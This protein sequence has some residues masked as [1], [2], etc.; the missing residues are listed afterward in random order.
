MLSWVWLACVA[1]VFGLVASAVNHIYG[2][3][4]KPCDRVERLDGAARA[5]GKIED[6][7]FRANAGDPARQERSVGE[8][9]SL[10][11]HVLGKSGYQAFYR[12]LSRLG[13][14]VARA[15][16]RAAGGQDQIDC[17]IPASAAFFRNASI[18]MRFVRENGGGDDFPA[19][20]FATCGTAGRSDLRIF[21][22]QRNR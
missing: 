21:R 9:S 17:A 7:R 1:Q 6:D 19:E 20:F 2:V 13:R 4:K 8:F 3:R 14:H 16:S 12:G 18:A 15:D 11:A 5:A 22:L 10:G